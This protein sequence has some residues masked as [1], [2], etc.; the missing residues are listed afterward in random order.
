MCR[1]PRPR[2]SVRVRG[3]K[4]PATCL[5][6]SDVIP[7]TRRLCLAVYSI[8]I[9]RACFLDNAGPPAHWR[10]LALQRMEQDTAGRAC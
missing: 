3:V 6:S 8:T 2:E 4:P 5:G 1:R 9:H 10:W 7:C